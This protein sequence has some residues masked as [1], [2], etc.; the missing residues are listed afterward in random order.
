MIFIHKKKEYIDEYLRKEIATKT[1]FKKNKIL[2]RSSKR[3]NPNI[4][5]INYHEFQY[6]KTIYV[7][8]GDELKS[9]N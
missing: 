3:S 7:L 9:I 8:N 1:G 6:K 5:N 4:P 2:L